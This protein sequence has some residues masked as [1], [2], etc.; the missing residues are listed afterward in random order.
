MTFPARV[1]AQLLANGL[2]AAS[3]LAACAPQGVLTA[4]GPVERA[5]PPDSQFAGFAQ[6]WDAARQAGLQSAATAPRL[7]AQLLAAGFSLVYDNCTDF[8]R[9]RGR[10][11]QNLALAS[12]SAGSLLPLASGALG[13][14]G[15]AGNA[16][17]VIGLAGGGL[18]SSI[19]L[20][21]SDFLFGGENVDN[22][23]VLTLNALSAHQNTV[24]GLARTDPA[25]VDFDW[26]ANQITDDQSVCEPPHILALTRQAIARGN[27]V[28]YTSATGGAGTVTPGIPIPTRVGVR[29][30]N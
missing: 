6:L 5:S 29:I 8:F 25:D 3:L 2:L 30:Q 19:D 27:V 1:P 21:A 14:A 24:H 22:V 17:A 12:D 20:V 11:Q 26:V 16:I 10:L 23:R 13:I 15:G 18:N 9:S 7:D 28:A 4:N